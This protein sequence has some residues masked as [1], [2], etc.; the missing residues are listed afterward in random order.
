MKRDEWLLLYVAMPIDGETPEL[1]PVRIMK[2]MFL[3]TQEHPGLKRL[4]GFAPYQYGP[5]STDI[6]R[7]L[8]SL[9]GRGDIRAR[10]V[11]GY[12][13]S[14]YSPTTA[15][16]KKLPRLTKDAGA[17]AVEDLK[18]VKG[19]V[20]SLRF[21]ELLREVYRRYPRYAA[22]TAVPHLKSQ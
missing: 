10:R 4:Y 13:W 11:Q 1:D 7:D 16:S 9:V 20:C 21:A 19:L 17:E 2:G 3:F 14:L 5:F 22:K 15:G 18:E 6:Y 12:S 8:D